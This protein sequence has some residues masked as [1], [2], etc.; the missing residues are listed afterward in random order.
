M[1]IDVIVVGGGILGLMCAYE[2]TKSHPEL[3]LALLESSGFF[4]DQTSGRNSGVMHAGLYY[5]TD[6][7]KHQ[8]C[9]EGRELWKEL[10]RKLSI[11]SHTCGKF[12]VAGHEKQQEQ[13]EALYERSRQNRVQGITK[14]SSEQI[15]S[16][17][18]FTQVVDGLYSPNSGILHVSQAVSQLKNW[19]YQHNIPC[20]PHQH[21]ENIEYKNGEFSLTS[22]GDTLKCDHLINCAGFGTI[23]LR[24]QLGLTDY[25]QYLVKGH[26]VRYS[27]KIETDALIY[28]LPPGNGGLGVHLTKDI[29]GQTFFGPDAW[30][31]EELDYSINE[32]SLENMWPAIAELFKTVEKKDLSLAYTGIRP[33]IRKSADDELE[34]DFLYQNKNKHG[35]EN[36]H[37]FLGI[38]SPGL[39]AAPALA[40][41]IKLF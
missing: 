41:L 31:V 18:G 37:E 35:I 34:P 27:K 38:E 15:Q 32:Q 1:K 17:Q 5:P 29:E 16:L 25:K 4:G 26:Y 36:Y 10:C 40:K 20:L 30:P 24:S 33:K 13:L 22:A 23:P 39:T 12:V 21:V 11:Q 7:L 6:S 3:S 14:M 8:S 28:P 19:L 9:L 2:L